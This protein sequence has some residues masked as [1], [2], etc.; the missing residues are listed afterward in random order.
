VLGG[1]VGLD[2]VVADGALGQGDGISSAECVAV[3]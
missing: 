3:V 1:D 2:G